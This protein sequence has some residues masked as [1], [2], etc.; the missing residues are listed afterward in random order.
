MSTKT[1]V[2]TGVGP[3]N[4][5]AL[6]RRFAAGGYRVAMLARSAEKLRD[7]E[8]EVP[9]SRTYPADVADA[10]SVRDTF[11][12]IRADLRDAVDL[13]KGPI[14]EDD[15]TEFVQKVEQLAD[16]IAWLRDHIASGKALDEELAALLEEGK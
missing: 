1:C 4:G 11:A 12:R 13:F 5:L 8:R 16:L 10:A 7:F 2:V 3:G 15:R 9:G 14:P 6:A